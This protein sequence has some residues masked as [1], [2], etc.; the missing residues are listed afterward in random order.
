MLPFGNFQSGVLILICACSYLTLA[1]MID[2]DRIIF[3]STSST[4]QHI[5]AVCMFLGGIFFLV[6]SIL[7]LPSWGRVW[8]MS[9]ANL[10]TLV[11]RIGSVLYLTGSS[12]SL[13]LIRYPPQPQF[14]FESLTEEDEDYCRTGGNPLLTPSKHHIGDDVSEVRVVSSKTLWIIVIVS[15]ILGAVLYIIGGLL[16]QY[17]HATV[18]G[19]LLWCV[20]SVLF[21]TG[22]FT[23]LYT[24]VLTFSNV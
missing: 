3:K 20:G 13:Y 14:K 8:T 15:Y 1:A 19:T 5:Y 7:Y 16:G 18:S 21:V 23:Q 24:V 9:A 2:V 22:A 6:A 10:G 17:F 12:I 11:F 4:L